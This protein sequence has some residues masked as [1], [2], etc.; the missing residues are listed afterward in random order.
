MASEL[1]AEILSLVN[2]GDL[3]DAA[4]RLAHLAGE[5][6]DDPEVARL[7]AIVLWKGGQQEEALKVLRDLLGRVPGDEDALRLAGG[8][9]MEANSSGAAAATYGHLCALPGAGI[10]DRLNWAEALTADGKYRQA[11]KVLEA[12]RP[13]A[14]S[15][16]AVRLRLADVYL[17]ENRRD[18]A[19][20]LLEEARKDTPDDLAILAA[21]ARLYAGRGQRSEG[22]RMM[23]RITEL[24]PA[25]AK[26]WLELGRFHYWA[27]EYPETLVALSRGLELAPNDDEIHYQI[28]DLYVRLKASEL[29]EQ[30]Y[31]RVIEIAPER[32]DDAEAAIAV[33]LFNRGDLAGAERVLQEMLARDPESFPARRGLIFVYD[34]THRHEEAL[35]LGEDLYRRSGGNPMIGFNRA[36][37]LLRLGRFQEG[38]AAWEVRFKTGLRSIESEQ[39]VWTGQAIAGKRLAVIWEQGFG[40]TIQCARLLPLLRPFGARVILVC[41]VGLKGLLERSGLADEVVELPIG[42]GEL[43]EHDYAVHLMSLPHILRIDL[44]NLPNQVPYL[45]PDSGLIEKWRQRMVKGPELRVGLVWSGSPTHSNDP[46]RSC[47]TDK[48]KLLAAVPDVRYFSLLRGPD[49]SQLDQLRGHLEIEELGSEFANFDDTAAAVM[50]VDLLISVDTSVAH[51]AGALARP[52]WLLLPVCPDW[53]WL[54]NR[55]DSPWYAT[56]TLIRQQRYQDWDGVFQT[57]ITRLREL[58]AARRAPQL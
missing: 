34:Q 7:G 1:T 37:A 56:M 19:L 2:S 57:V 25:N 26:A 39:P 28:G 21:L 31:R 29:A 3:A 11:T 16:P 38:W 4:D 41:Q 13:Y 54:T 32:R 33:T 9:Q 49:A 22:L 18:E 14:Q 23:K 8:L 17:G 45:K 10:Q 6:P 5:R 15:F 43:P 27:N 55:D 52:V 50:N 30:H 53:R 44:G 40:D 58:S 42:Y 51:L 47:P 36:L 35:V 24:Q 20:A 48:L 46:N 12:L